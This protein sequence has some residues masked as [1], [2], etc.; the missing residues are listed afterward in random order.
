MASDLA[1]PAV[2]VAVKVADPVVLMI[3]IQRKSLN[4]VIAHWGFEHSQITGP[5]SKRV[6]ST[7]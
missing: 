6:E 1:Q 3:I 7:A 4:G 5:C 2:V